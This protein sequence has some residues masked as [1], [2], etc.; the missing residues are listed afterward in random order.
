ME[1]AAPPGEAGGRSTSGVLLRRPEPR[2]RPGDPPPQRGRFPS[3]SWLP[4]LHF[5]RGREGGHGGAP[6]RG[7]RGGAGL[8]RGG[9]GGGAARAVR[10][11]G[12]RAG[13]RGAGAAGGRGPPPR[14]AR[15]P[16]A[17]QR[18]GAAVGAGVL[19]GPGGGPRGVGR[20][21]RAGECRAARARG[22][23][24]PGATPRRA[25][26]AASGCAG[27]LRGPGAPPPPWG[28]PLA[29]PRWCPP[30]GP[31]LGRARGRPSGRGS[32]GLPGGS[33]RLGVARAGR[34]AGPTTR[35]RAGA[36]GVP[37]RASGA[38]ERRGA[39][40]AREDPP[41]VHG[42]PRGHPG[43]EPLS[44]CPCAAAPTASRTGGRALPVGLLLEPG[45]GLERGWEAALRAPR[46][47][48]GGSQSR[49]WRCWATRR[50]TFRNP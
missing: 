25:A 16:G 39:R 10:G 13:G 21:A 40:R 6:R 18:A 8:P 12:A 31:R 33:G 27:A 9:P 2:A 7:V 29:G 36:S 34:S 43:G 14:G 26:A 41:P 35:S 48:R 28:A 23:G 3:A 49:S 5:E 19:V 50:A 20:G 42:V 46:G 1:S 38:P 4:P 44:S 32:G 22:G 45:P 11:R 17:R 30:S 15:R 24:R 47:T 37:Q